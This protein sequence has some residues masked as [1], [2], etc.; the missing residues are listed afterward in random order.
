MNTQKCKKIVRE[1]G[2]E[3]EKGREGDRKLRAVA[4][5]AAARVQYCFTLNGMKF[6]SRR[7]RRMR[8]NILEH[9]LSELNEYF[10]EH[11]CS[12]IVHELFHEFPSYSANSA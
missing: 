3:A 2:K 5:S 8:R 6:V 1:Q 12:E 7:I 10:L 9:E 4:R 11:E